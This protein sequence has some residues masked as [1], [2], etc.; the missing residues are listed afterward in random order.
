MKRKQLKFISIFS[1]CLLG[2]NF[3]FTSCDKDN[4]TFYEGY[5]LIRKSGTYKYRIVLDDGYLL[6]PRESYLNPDKVKDSCRMFLRFNIL[7]ETDSCANVRITYADTILTKPILPYNTSNAEKAGHAPVKITKYWFAHGFLNFEFM[8]AG[9]YPSNPNKIHTVNLLQYPSENG[10]LTFEFRHNDF[11]DRRDQLY[12][13]VV[14]F[15]ILS[16]TEGMEKPIS[17]SVKYN[18]SANTS[19]TLEMTYR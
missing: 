2:I 18:D 6:N 1:L 10:K 7:E 14:S 5:G 3:L 8:F 11:K 16:L 15:P 19:R 9:S 12:L 4:V 17:M 13:G